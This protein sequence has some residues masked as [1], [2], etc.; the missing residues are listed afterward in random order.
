M[1]RNTIGL[2][3]L[4]GELEQIHDIQR[5]LEATPDYSI[6]SS[7]RL[8][9]S[10]D[11][12]T[13]F[14]V[15]PPGTGVDAKFVYGIQLDDATIGCID[16]IRG[17]P[18]GETAMLG[19]LLLS[20]KYQRAHLGSEAYLLLEKELLRWPEINT[21]RI[22]IIATN[23]QVIPFW[24]KMGFIDTGIRRPYECGEYKTQSY[25]YEKRIA[26]VGSDDI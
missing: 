5:V 25:I 15:H 7:G 10:T 23:E 16:V 1:L 26:Q 22:G 19:L 11:A 24:K 4:K 8:P 18:N 9:A 2:R 21:V 17:Y 20:E 12:A 3:R 13:L 14:E 6:K